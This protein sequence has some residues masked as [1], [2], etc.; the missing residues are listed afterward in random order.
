MNSK[1]IKFIT[2]LLVVVMSMSFLVAC[3]SNDDS[4]KK[5]QLET[6]VNQNN[7]NEE[8]D[9]KEEDLEIRVAGSDSGFPNPYVFQSLR[10]IG[11]NNKLIF[12]TLLERG[13]EDIVPWIAENYQI[14]EDGLTYTFTIREG[15]KWHDGEDL[16]AEDVK[17]SIDKYVEVPAAKDN[18]RID[19]EP[20]IKEVRVDGRDVIVEV[21]VANVKVLNSVGFVEILPKHIWENVEDPTSF[22]APESAIGSGPYKLVEYNAEVGSYAYEAFEDYWREVPIKKFYQI[23]VSDSV[24]A[25]ENGEIDLLS[26]SGDLVDRYKNNPEYKVITSPAFTGNKMLLNMEKRPEL[27]DKDLR[28]ALYYGINR[29]EIVE[30]VYRGA[31]KTAS[32]GYLSVDHVMYNDKVVKY[33]YNP[34]KAK[35]LLKGKTYDFELVTSDRQNDIKT[36]ELI[37]L[38]LEEI[39]INL[40]IKSMDG[41]SRDN[42]SKLGEFDLLITGAGGWGEDPDML[43][44]QYSSK[45]DKTGVQGIARGYK[46]EIIDKLAEK[47]LYE[48]NPEKRKEIV[49]ELQEVISEEIPIIP[50]VNNTMQYAFKPAKYDG[51]AFAFNYDKT[52]LNKVSFVK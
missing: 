16:T 7:A 49:F 29:D 4:G 40:N 50:L 11:F 18:L 9:V 47:Q 1:R 37:K 17:F 33:D 38:H 44:T 28:K 31:A 42:I 27:L 13:E 39:G 35:E 21:H 12:D 23:P 2:L 22:D 45:I 19:D 5:D 32:A 30:K 24:L 51:W 15:L 36:A 3:G 41:K 6:E 20:F 10:S 52:N 14:S 26:V 46:N 34:E 48:T 8:E 25:F 43:R